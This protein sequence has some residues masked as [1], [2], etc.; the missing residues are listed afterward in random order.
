MSSQ[1]VLNHGPLPLP[2]FLP[3]GTLGVVRAVDARD[4]HEAGVEAMVMNVFHLMQKPGSTTIESLGGLHQMSAWSGPI[5]TDSGGFQAYSLIRQNPRAGRLSDSGITFLPEGAER[6]FQ[7]TP[8]KSVQL[9]LAYGADI[10]ITL[11][12][13]THVDDSGAEQ[14]TSVER[15][16]R[17]ARRCRDEF[18]RQVRQRRMGAGRPL[19]FGVVQGG[20]DPALR[21]ACAEALLEIG[22]DGFGFGGWPLDAKGNLLSEILALT[23]GLI[24]PHLPMH[25][26]GVGHPE[27]VAACAR[28]GYQIFD[29]A[30]PTRD[31][32]SGRLYAFTGDPAAPGFRLSGAWFDQV[33]V[34][35]KK[36]IKATGPVYPGCD[37]RS[38]QHYSLGYLHHLHKVGETLF[39]RLATIHNLRFMLRLMAL[40]RAEG[41]GQLAPPP[42]A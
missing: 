1:L 8:E 22:F 37:C 31:A 14:R 27:S 10:V 11:D 42:A 9:Q 4:L 13:C 38:C 41:A 39:L 21:R 7:L 12:D 25:A 28:M 33:Y 17:W 30:L 35:D 3:D 23:R 5:I 15:T 16:I 34:A 40:L 26:L 20:G 24:P 6:K 2:T 29:S 36:H 18:D 19:L 32:R